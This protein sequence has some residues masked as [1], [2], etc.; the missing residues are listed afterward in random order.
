[1]INGNSPKIEKF[2]KRRPI[3]LPG[4]LN[5]NEASPN[6]KNSVNIYNPGTQRTKHTRLPQVLHLQT[7]SVRVAILK[8]RADPEGQ[9]VQ[10]LTNLFDAG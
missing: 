5:D 9:I 4:G 7:I 10:T 8:R 1:M 6:T 2:S 3:C